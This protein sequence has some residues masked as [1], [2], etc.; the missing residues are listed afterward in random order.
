VTDSDDGAA[1]PPTEIE[2]EPPSPSV[3]LADLL[4]VDPAPSIVSDSDEG[5]ALPPTE[6]E[7]PSYRLLAL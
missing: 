4:S 5:A 1:L 6:I 2:S 7:L 3:P